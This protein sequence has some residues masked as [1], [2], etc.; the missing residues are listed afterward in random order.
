[1]HRPASGDSCRVDQA[2]DAATECDRLPDQRHHRR[3]VGHVDGGEEPAILPASF[4]RDG[5][6]H[7]IGTDNAPPFGEE[8]VAVARPMPEAAP[9]TM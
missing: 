6:R 3:L 7:Q 5:C 9:V 2:L 1:M 4:R 8:P